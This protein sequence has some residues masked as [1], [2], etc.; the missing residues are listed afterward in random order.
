[1]NKNEAKQKIDDLRI[2]LTKHNYNYYVLSQPVI[3]DFDYDM[4]MKELE[5]L[6]QKFP[7]FDNINSPTK[8]VGSD[9]SNEFKQIAHDYPMLSLGNTYNTGELIDFDKRIKNIIGDETSFNY[10]CELK[11]DGTAISIKYRNGTLYQAVTRGN[12]IKGDDVTENVRTI[13][14]VPLT[15]QG[16]DY[17]EEFEVRGEII[18][19]HKTFDRLNAERIESGETAFANPRNAASGTIKMKSSALVAKR[20]LDAFLYDMLGE[21]LPSNS[22]FENLNKLKTWGFKIS[23]YSKRCADI[24]EVFDFITEWDEKRRQLPFDIDGIVLKVDSLSLRN[25]L[26]MTGKSPRWAISYKFK[27]EQI[28]TELLSV[29][30]Q[31]GR[32]GA[33]TPVAN[34]KPVQLAGTT[35]KR[36]SLHNADIISELDIRIGDTVFVE[37]GGEIIPK[38]TGVDFAKRTAELKKTEFP[39]HCPACGAS[40]IRTEGE[41]QHYCPNASGCPNQIKGKIEHFVGRNAMNINCGEATIKALYKAGYI[42]NIGD[43]YKLTFEQ[44]I[45]LEGFKEKSANNLLESINKS[46]EVPF[47]RLLFALGIRYVGN[48]VAKVLAENMKDIDAIQQANFEQLTAIDE[49]GEKIAE[50][51]IHW[52]KDEQNIHLLNELK[53]A[54]LQ[55]SIKEDE[56]KINLLNGAKIVISGTFEKYSREELKKM[57]A[58]FGGKPVSS[59]TKNTDF[60]LEGEKSGPAKIA[61]VEKLGIK[62]IKEEE[63]LAMINKK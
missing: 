51:L 61:K 58:Q 5:D 23:E 38:I 41:A 40:L 55:F 48:I 16:K 47:E 10:I 28:A 21:K 1:M 24:K 27:A 50:S 2:K 22:H 25:E 44:I 49:I 37:K 43:L 63:F 18:M 8:R 45:S 20:N 11:F 3:S 35:V 62:R 30:Y 31:V 52:F 54:G 36:A 32:T 14:S 34:L 15:L 59:V 13:R 9:I 6:E 12:G 39:E 60:F 19:P 42:K 29:E 46:K 53:N 17:P 56:N 33:I 26:G 57:I 7:E 4:L